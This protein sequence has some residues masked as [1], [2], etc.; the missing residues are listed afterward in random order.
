MVPL[1]PV[2]PVQPVQPVAGSNRRVHVVL[3]GMT[4]D[5]KAGKSAEQNLEQMK[6]LFQGGLNPEHLGATIVIRGKDVTPR[7]ILAAIDGLNVA[8]DEALFVYCHIHGGYDARYQGADPSQGHFF[9]LGDNGDLMRKDLW[10]HARARKAALTVLVTESC[11]VRSEASPY[12][13]PPVRFQLVRENPAL[14]ALFLRTRGYIDVNAC[15]RGESSWNYGGGRGSFFTNSFVEMFYPH[16]GSPITDRANVRWPELVRAA[17]DKASKIFQE[18][19]RAVLANAQNY[20]MNLVDQYRAQGD[21]RAV[22][23]Q[24][25]FQGEPAPPV[26]PLPPVA[27]GP[28]GRWVGTEDLPGYGP[29]VF[30]LQPAGA[31]GAAG[32]VAYM[33]DKDGR[34][35]GTWKLEGTV[36]TLAFYEGSVL[37]R[38][39]YAGDT[40]A[41]TATSG[42]RTWNW[43]VRR[44][45]VAPPQPP[46]VPQPPVQP[47]VQP[48]AVAGIAGSW[49]GMCYGIG[50]PFPM[51]FDI[52]PAGTVVT[53]TKA[54]GRLEGTWRL[55][56]ND[57]TLA[58]FNGELVFRGSLAGNTIAGSATWKGEIWTW[59]VSRQ[60]TTPPPGVP[61]PIGPGPAVPPS[62]PASVQ[63][64]GRWVGSEDLKGYGQLVMELQDGGIAFM[65]DK[66]GRNQ[67]T[68]GVQGNAVTLTFYKGTVAYRGTLA[69]NAITGTANNGSVQWGFTLRRDVPAPSGPPAPS[70]PMIAT[71]SKPDGSAV[72]S[73]FI[74]DLSQAAPLSR[75]AAP[76]PASVNADRLR[77]W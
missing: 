39:T 47:P 7:G 56:G 15:S 5:P 42:N 71:R 2:Q 13:A 21:Q 73:L 14:V 24:M 69:G 58:F 48:P 36:L 17:G 33:T 54:Y 3:V 68:W 72:A 61:G 29:L 32:A 25:N 27:A 26:P 35:P 11:Y 18:S 53:V 4:D 8:P 43:S 22:I 76:L 28:A 1:P 57:V 77:G 34:R 37:Y 46:V 75:S 63:L 41:G 51:T 52:A 50:E 16:P 62:Q 64:V 60:G 19:R 10:Q 65:I 6:T 70:A 23:L 45:G 20:D 40:V 59:R 38:G 66:D 74:H 67:G 12:P 44:E 31:P 49:A 9:W 55:Q 30:E